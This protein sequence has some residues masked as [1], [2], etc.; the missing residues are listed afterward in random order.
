LAWQ[1]ATSA[2]TDWGPT[3]ARC[4]SSAQ[5]DGLKLETATSIEYDGMLWTE[6]ALTPTADLELSDLSLRIPLRAEHA[7][8]LHHVRPS[9]LEDTAGS[10]PEAGFEAVGFMPYVW[11]GD[12]DRGLAWFAESEFGWTAQSGQPVV[13]VK[14]ADDRVDLRIHILNVPTKLSRPL[15]LAFG[16]QATPVKPRPGNARGWRLGNL[17]TAEN[18]NDPS[19]GNLQVIWPNGNLLA[20]GYPWPADPTRFRQLVRELHAKGTRV[21]PYVNLNF[22]AV[23]TPE[24]PYYSPDWLDPARCFNSGDVAQMGGATLGACPS[25]TAWRDFIAYKLARFVDEFE[26]D[27][28]YVDCWNPSS[29]L[30]EDHGCGWRDRQGN[31]FGRFS[32]RG[33]REIVRRVREV[34]T[35]RRPDAHIIIHMSTS[36]CIPMLSFADSM[37][38]GEQYQATTQDP[39]DDYLGIVPLDKW[40]AENTGRQWGLF[41]FF[42]PEF[43]GGNRQAITPTARLMGLMLLHDCSPWPIWCNS[44]VIFDAWAAAD[45]FGIV[46]AEFLPYW[47]PNGVTPDRPEVV[48]SVYR[49]PGAVLLVALNTSRTQAI[50]GLRVDAAKLGLSPGF[51]AREAADDTELPIADGAVQVAL[52]ARGYRAVVL[53]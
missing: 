1:T 28:L 50:C 46:D 42:L 36:V 19:R 14:R 18:L 6:L 17:G 32:I 8:Y 20:Y 41:P 49:K 51:T 29:C 35:D 13:Q 26:V 39:K 4:T 34:L 22:L 23:P 2:I 44:Q 52:P 30:V 31:L 33:S 16:L 38:D 37:L 43:T 10:L 24:F 15:K 47:E 3:R 27:G 5:G 12:D 53:R 9:W 11:L 7:R 45:R 48:T 25:V 21:L 40:R